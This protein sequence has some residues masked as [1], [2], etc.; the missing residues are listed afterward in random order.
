MAHGA[1]EVE[2]AL[3]PVTALAGQPHG[4][5]PGEGVDGLAQR[6]HLLAG[7]VHEVDVL[8]QGLAQ[9][10][11][12]G[13]DPPV[14]HQCPTDLAL[15]LLLELVDAALVLVLLQALLERGERLGRLVPRLVHELVEHRVEVEVPQGAVEV[16]GAPDRAARLHPCVAAHR[17][18]GH[19]PHQRLITALERLEEHLGDLLGRHVLAAAR[20]GAGTVALHLLLLLQLLQQLGQG[21]LVAVAEAELR[22][23]Q[24]EVHLEH[25]L[26]GAPVGVVLHQGGGQRVLEGLAVL[27]RDVLDRLHGVEVLGEAHGE[28]GL[29][30][31]LDEPGQQLGDRLAR[32]QLGLIGHGAATSPPRPS[33]SCRSPGRAPAAPWRCRS[34]T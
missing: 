15:D 33:G 32:S 22:A 17:L 27:Q 28:P 3:A 1:A 19:R 10:A 29:P 12:H 9:G 31:L 13:L 16:V 26:E 20:T 6:G 2:G 24:R 18:A 34:G 7:G 21:V 11:G 4:Q 30:E 14:G 23:A 5:L 8:R 25:R